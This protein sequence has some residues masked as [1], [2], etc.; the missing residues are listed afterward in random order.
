MTLWE[1]IDKIESEFGKDLLKSKKVTVSKNY[2]NVRTW[3]VEVDEKV[4][5]QEILRKKNLPEQILF[6]TKNANNVEECIKSLEEIG[7]KSPPVQELITLLKTKFKGSVTNLIINGYLE[8]FIPRFVY[9]D[10]YSIMKGRISIQNLNQK[11][12]Q[13]VVD[14]S[15]RTFLSLLKLAGVQLEDL[16]KEQ[17]YERLKADL[18]AASI[19]IT[20]EVFKFWSQNKQL[21]V[22]FD[23]SNA[24]PTDSPPLNQGTILH[25]RIKNN[26]HRVTVPFDERSRGFVWFFS[27]FAYFSQIEEKDFDLVLLLDEPGLSLHAKAQYDFLNFIDERL[28]PKYQVIYTTHSPFMIEPTKLKN[29]RTVQDLDNR[30]TVISA[31]VLRT[32]KDTVFPLQAA[33][34]YELAQ[35]LFIGP[36]CLLVEG[37]SDLIFLQILSDVSNQKGKEYLKP[38]WVLVPVG[39]ADKLST[40]VSLLGANQLNI[41]VLMDTSSKDMQRIKFLQQNALL[42]KNGLINIGDVIGSENADIED[43]FEPEFYLELVNGAYSKELSKP[44]TEKLLTSKNPR[45][46]KRLEEYFKEKNIS[47]GIFSHYKASVYL[48][49]YQNVLIDKLSDET[50]N[51]AAKLFE[52]INALIS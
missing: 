8:K 19:S 1:E 35:T 2:K 33:L 31:D 13:G 49:K 18:E 47:D 3:Q 7:D 52:K 44:I 24:N 20:D 39:G 32:D 36:N 25:V 22:E 10:D 6:R 26:R 16:Q 14:D 51:Y 30:G 46:V 42:S 12:A 43:I 34:G 15:D 29:V 38:R 27:F 5:I 9:F 37:S 17:N 41:A 11:K 48:L 50:I 40:F 23:I 45:I 4:V 28:A 21:E